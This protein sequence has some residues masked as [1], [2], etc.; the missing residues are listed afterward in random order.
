VSGP[1]VVQLTTDELEQLVRKAVRVELAERG[2][3]AAKEVMSKADVAKLFGVTERSIQTW[4]VREGMPHKKGH[5]GRLSFLR[6][7][8]ATWA[9]EH[10]VVMKGKAA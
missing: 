9:K 5:G 10:G 3:E 2:Y 7:E 8:V 1:M 6:D 4:M